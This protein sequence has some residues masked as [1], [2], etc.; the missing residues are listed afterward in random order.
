M[1]ISINEPFSFD[2]VGL[3]HYVPLVG[4]IGVAFSRRSD[5]TR[6]I[7]G[8]SL[9]WGRKILSG[10][11]VG[12]SF[13]MSMENNTPAAS[14]GLG[15]FVGN[16]ELDSMDSPRRNL[17]ALK[18]LDRINLGVTVQ[19]LPLSQ[20]L[21]DPSVLFGFSYL[22]TNSRFLLNTGYHLKTPANTTH[23][24]LGY[25][26]SRYITLFA[27]SE[28]FELDKAAV[29]LAFTQHNFLL[30]MSY[31]QEL[32]KV[33]VTLSARISPR[34]R[35]L[36]DPHYRRGR[37]HFRAGADKLATSELRKYLSY[38][39]A[40]AKN[41]T[42]R[43]IVRYLR[44]KLTRKQARIDS[45]FAQAQGF[46]EQKK[47]QTLRAAYSYTRI[48]AL[49]QNNL[50]ARIKLAALEP[51][52][53]RFVE[54]WIADG[55]YEYEVGDYEKS[56]I[57]F[58]KVLLFRKGNKFA[59]DY[60]ARIDKFYADLGQDHFFRG[61]GFLSN[62]N[63]DRAKQE[64][65][66]ALK[67]N[68]E[69]QD[70]KRYLNITDQRFRQ[71]EARVDS[72]RKLAASLA[73]D[74]KFRSAVSKYKEVLASGAE[75]DAVKAEISR[76]E[77]KLQQQQAS[78]AKKRRA[79]SA[80]F[81]KAQAAFELKDWQRAYDLDS[82]GLKILPNSSQ[83]IGR[84]RNAR[85]KLQ[86]ASLLAV[87]RLDLTDRNYREALTN[88]QRAAELDPG[89]S[90]VQSSLSRTRGR[91]DELVKGYFDEGINLYTQDKYQE[92]ITKWELALSLDP[93]H[94]GSLDYKSQ[95]ED[96]ITALRAIKR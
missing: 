66:L 53:D 48:L 75:D 22:V 85:K 83:A 35:E 2:F 18:A 28:D 40:G 73:K 21:F 92:A 86:A 29:G 59:K 90:E 62:K 13:T 56:G 23:I 4:T 57:N 54:R 30:N 47:P 32:Q 6:V 71:Q 39:L 49:D 67:Y 93:T 20:K 17:P 95:A 58:K 69:M 11:S 33:L 16:L 8:G 82:A 72:L 77:S 1:L 74:N 46:L 44:F 27:G 36:A 19:G 60:L 64:F 80:Y 70:A 45:L 9:A 87:G 91:I 78:I 25:K 79:A 84:R 15:L 76:L 51:R 52:V 14:V 81:T 26:L 12:S 37:A 88:F 42:A 10:L 38:D 7:D 3:T 31:S 89:N 41:D 65:N 5:S 68:P 55:I 34:A 43:S 50:K 24:G 61:V 63:Y 96:R 94:K